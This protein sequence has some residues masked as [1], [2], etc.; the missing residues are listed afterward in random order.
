[1][2]FISKL[3]TLIALLK[4]D[5]IALKQEIKPEFL[6]S[7]A[8][9]IRHI[10]N[11]AYVLTGAGLSYAF[12]PFYFVGLIPT[13]SILRVMAESS[14]ML[15]DFEG[16]RFIDYELTLPLKVNIIFL[17]KIFLLSL[18]FIV[19]SLPLIPIGFFLLPNKHLFNIQLA[20]FIII[21]I[22]ANI[23]ISCMILWLVGWIKSVSKIGSIWIRYL[24]TLWLF[25]C[26]F[27]PWKLFFA[28]YPVWALFNLFNPITY[29]MEGLRASTLG[30]S[31]YLDYWICLIIIIIFS[32][33]FALQGLSLLKKRLD[34]V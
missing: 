16:E 15:S 20:K 24:H 8:M 5:C 18:K 27:F 26:L 2:G 33:L 34:V 6:N 30:Q 23:M 12:G 19:L 3:Y 25:G 1:M 11:F 4:R 28:L 13:I 22:A 29:V 7:F 14:S 9:P 21:F 32:L 10:I 31:D 17:R